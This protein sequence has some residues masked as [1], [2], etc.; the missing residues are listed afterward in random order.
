[1]IN[2]SVCVLSDFRAHLLVH[3]TATSGC[4]LAVFGSAR[5]GRVAETLWRTITGHWISEDWA[6]VSRVLCTED[7]DSTQ[8]KTGDNIHRA[9]VTILLDLDIGRNMVTFT[10]DRG[11]NIIAALRTDERL[12]CIALERKCRDDSLTVGDGNCDFM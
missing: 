3:W 11:A 1:M 5:V 7:F 10:T 6:L 8:K 12:D 4:W 2:V 9:I